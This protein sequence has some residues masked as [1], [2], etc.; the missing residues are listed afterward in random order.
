MVGFSFED[1]TVTTWGTGAGPDAP[2]RW[3]AR[4]H[5][6]FV[7]EF[8]A[9]RLTPVE[10]LYDLAR[11]ALDASCGLAGCTGEPEWKR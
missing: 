10:D 11:A 5:A 1:L 9:D 4:S 7:V 6:G 3:R 2:Q 8:Y